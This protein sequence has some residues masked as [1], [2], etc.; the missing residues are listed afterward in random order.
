M[1]T[2]QVKPDEVGGAQ[3]G[4]GR[5]V[6]R[7][8]VRGIPSAAVG[9]AQAFIPGEAAHQ[10]DESDEWTTDTDDIEIVRD[11]YDQWRSHFNEVFCVVEESNLKE[12]KE[13]LR[14]FHTD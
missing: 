9:G 12:G 3:V 6:E 5:L 2:G 11:L 13:W 14:S 8:E 1:V 7:D 4:D 10:D